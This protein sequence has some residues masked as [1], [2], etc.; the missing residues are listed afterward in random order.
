MHEGSDREINFNNQ[1]MFWKNEIER[2]RPDGK[3]YIKSQ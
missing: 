3:L 2:N 1:G